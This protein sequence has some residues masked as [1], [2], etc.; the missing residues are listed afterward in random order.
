MIYLTLRICS[1]MTVTM[2]FYNSSERLLREDLQIINNLVILREALF[3]HPGL[4]KFQELLLQIFLFI[5]TNKWH[6]VV[7]I[8]E[9]PSR[10]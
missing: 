9:A 4:V 10:R 6:I 3:H 2:K 8:E 1:M 5:N 7:L